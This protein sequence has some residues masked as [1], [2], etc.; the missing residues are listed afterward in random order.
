MRLSLSLFVGVL[1]A[2]SLLVVCGS[3]IQA[4][5]QSTDG[6]KRSAD[7]KVSK[8]GR[9]QFYSMQA[10]LFSALATARALEE[11]TEGESDPDFSLSRTLISTTS[12]SIQGTDTSSV[13][14]GQAIHGLEKSEAMKTMRNELN[15]ATKAADEAHTAADSHGSIG[16]QAKN[17][18]AHLLRAMTALVELADEAGIRALDAPGAEAINNA[19]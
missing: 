11:I 7:V 9:E 1:F 13:A 12:R 18:V 19:R 4:Q 15:A 14:L 2:T 10:S 8:T 5:R 6:S 16:P 17:M 3:P